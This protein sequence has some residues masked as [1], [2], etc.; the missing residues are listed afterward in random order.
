YEFHRLV[1]EMPAG[2]NFAAALRRVLRIQPSY[3]QYQ[4]DLWV[5]LA[6]TH[7]KKDGYYVD[8][9]SSDGEFI[10]NTFLLDQ[11]GWKG[12]CIDPF[13]QNRRRRTSQ[14][15]NHTALPQ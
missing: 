11:M 14:I 1:Y 6:E 10:S 8:V 13:P 15:S 12:V 9:G 7:G 5:A 3:G 2:E 4:Q